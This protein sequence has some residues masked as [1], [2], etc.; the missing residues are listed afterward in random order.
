M[1]CT[2]IIPSKS[3]SEPNRLPNQYVPMKKNTET[4]NKKLLEIEAIKKILLS[5]QAE[6]ELE[7]HMIDVD[8]QAREIC[9]SG[10][11]AMD[12]LRKPLVSDYDL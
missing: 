11:I 10:E 7:K 8:K 6:K 3:K 1:T 12:V 9:G 5:K 2:R 4:R